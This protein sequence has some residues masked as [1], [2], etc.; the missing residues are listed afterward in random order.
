[1]EQ[2]NLS[3]VLPAHNESSCIGNTI[4][5]INAYAEQRGLRIEIVIVDDGSTDE[6]AEILR[7]C[8]KIYSV[9]SSNIQI[10]IL[11]NSHR[12]DKGYAVRRGMLEACGDIVM[13]C[14][15]DLSTPM[16]QLDELLPWLDRGF[17]VVIGSR[18]VADSVLAPPQPL[19]RRIMGSVFRWIRKR[20]MLK[21][22]HDTQCG[23]KVFSRDAAMQIFQAQTTRGPAFD[24][25]VLAI[26]WTLGYKIKEVGVLW[27]NTAD[28]R[29]RP[30]RDGLNM[31]VSL[32][33][34]RW[35]LRQATRIGEH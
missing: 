13:F 4:D 24:C 21:E 12:M 9:E 6:T 15:A 7:T 20:V 35:R 22:I 31:L 14:D 16:Q 33:R 17:D 25:E 29:I 32:I 18:C 30:L 10:C 11:T 26:A 28:S 8:D 19:V 2:T 27:R 3:V 1:M 34:I 23:F 5:E